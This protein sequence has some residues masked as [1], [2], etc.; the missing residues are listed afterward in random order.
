[1][2]ETLELL[3]YFPD[4]V[5]PKE[6]LETLRLTVRAL[7]K[8]EDGKFGF[9]KIEGEDELGYHN[10]LDLCGGGV[11]E[12]ESLDQAMIRETGEELGFAVRQ[13][14]C[15]GP[16]AYDYHLIRRRTLEYLYIVEV[17]TGS[18]KTDRTEAERLL[19]KEIEWLSLE[20]ALK[21]LKQVSGSIWA[22]MI[23]ARHLF[24]VEYY[25]KTLTA[26]KSKGEA[27]ES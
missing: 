22:G 19:I 11:E 4:T 25:L 13:L 24:F 20:E 14:S 3:K 23:Q 27:R 1:M 16:V 10:Y 9:L 6:P 15:L 7:V 5:F 26:S 12:G 2:D 21:R 8:R 17:D 18:Q